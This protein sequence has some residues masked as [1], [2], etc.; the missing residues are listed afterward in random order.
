MKTLQELAFNAIPNPGL[1]ARTFLVPWHPLAVKL[2]E[3]EYE[4]Q[5]NIFHEQHRTQFRCVCK[6]FFE[7]V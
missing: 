3:K 4:T 6:S 7:V 5:P 2:E 1:M